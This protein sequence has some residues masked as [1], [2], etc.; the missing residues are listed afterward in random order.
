MVHH[1]VTPEAR[2]PEPS[3]LK[4]VLKAAIRCAPRHIRPQCAAAEVN[5][6]LLSFFFQRRRHV[7]A[8]FFVQCVINQRRASRHA[9]CRHRLPERSSGGYGARMNERRRR[10][11]S[12][13]EES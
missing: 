5:A 11:T 1:E 4:A 3:A 9:G 10:S 8:A 2:L 7:H 6:E 13:P 12:R